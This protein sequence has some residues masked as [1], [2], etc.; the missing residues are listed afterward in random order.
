MKCQDLFSLKKK[1][2]KLKVSSAAVDICALRVY[3]TSFDFDVVSCT[4]I[5]MR[6][7]VLTRR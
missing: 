4:F 2:K 7:R 6:E 1:K 5:N 3:Y